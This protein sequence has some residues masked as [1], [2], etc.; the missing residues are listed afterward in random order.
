MVHEFEHSFLHSDAHIYLHTY[1][2]KH[3]DPHAVNWIWISSGHGIHAKARPRLTCLFLSPVGRIDY[4]TL[5][6]LNHSACLLATPYTLVHFI[7]CLIM[8]I[9]LSVTT[10]IDHN[11]EPNSLLCLSHSQLET[12]AIQALVENL[13]HRS[14]LWDDPA[15]SSD[16]LWLC[17]AYLR[18]HK[19]WRMNYLRL[20]AAA[21]GC[22]RGAD[23]NSLSFSTQDLWSLQHG[24]DH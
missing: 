9:F 4:L 2:H 1:H 16:S 5:A 21:C 7:W 6:L 3:T 22:G 10:L 23:V 15:G 20:L 17:L 19:P 18:H 12:P 14:T 24:C 13:R 8:D 11:N